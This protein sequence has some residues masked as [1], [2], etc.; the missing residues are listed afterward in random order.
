MQQVFSGRMLS[1]KWTKTERSVAISDVVYLAESEN[2]D[3]SYTMG[4]VE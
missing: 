4:G 1:H 3:P 2:G